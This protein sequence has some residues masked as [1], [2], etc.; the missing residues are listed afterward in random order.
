MKNIFI[1]CAF[2]LT[3]SCSH[4]GLDEEQMNAILHRFTKDQQK[5]RHL[6]TIGTGSAMPDKIKKFIVRF[7]SN[8]KLDRNQARTLILDCANDLLIMVNDDEII[9]PFLIE[10]PFTYNNIDIVI[11]FVN[12]KGEIRLCPYTAMVAI[13]DGL[14]GTFDYDPVSKRMI[15]EHVESIKVSPKLCPSPYRI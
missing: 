2:L 6:E 11:C 10:Y 7:I 1:F 12:E 4:L 9:R 13:D 5:E 14:I 15:N 3:S 8:E